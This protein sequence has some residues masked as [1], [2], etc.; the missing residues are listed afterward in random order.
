MGRLFLLKKIED[1]G[2]NQDAAAIFHARVPELTATTDVKLNERRS[3]R[4]LTTPD[5]L[6]APDIFRDHRCKA[7]RSTFPAD[8]SRLKARRRS[9]D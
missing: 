2:V 7:A 8:G 3:L 9:H 4:G 6:I 1:F 5:R